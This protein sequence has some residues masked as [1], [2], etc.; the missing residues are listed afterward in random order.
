MKYLPY[1]FKDKICIGNSCVDKVNLKILKGNVGFTLNTFTEPKPF[2]LFSE[3]DFGGWSSIR[4][5]SFVP[6]ISFGEGKNSV[7]SYKIFD[8]NYMIT[9]FE[10]VNYAGLQMDLDASEMSDVTSIFPNGFKSFQPKSK[11]GNLLNNSCLS[12][13]NIIHEPNGNN[14]VIQAIPCDLATDIYYIARDDITKEHTHEDDDD[15]HFHQHNQSEAYHFE[16]GSGSDSGSDS[17]SG[18]I[19]SGKCIPESVLEKDAIKW[20]EDGCENRSAKADPR[21]V[22][23]ND[24]GSSRYYTLH[25]D[26]DSL[27]DGQE[28]I[29]LCPGSLH[30]CA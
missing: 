15:I 10:D 30:R 5:T 20:A 1:N 7:K 28:P 26:N 9:A 25:N 14:S 4:S 2:R 27:P 3:V 23:V 18:K 22:L 11:A 12:V 19:P 29:Q 17:G 24:T 13:Q 21:R 8:T 6:Q 16:G